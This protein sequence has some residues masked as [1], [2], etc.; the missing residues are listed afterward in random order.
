[1]AG[2]AEAIL[3]DPEQRERVQ[4]TA[5]LLLTLARL[6]EEEAAGLLETDPATP[7]SE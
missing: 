5:E 3:R 2:L 6:S 4:R 7:L 1:V